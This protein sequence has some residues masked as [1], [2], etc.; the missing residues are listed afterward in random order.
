MA[1]QPP[2]LRGDTL[3]INFERRTAAATDI[4]APA[5]SVRQT[6]R[7]CSGVTTTDRGP[8]GANY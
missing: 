1:Q 4:V 7:P 6:G 5:S 8:A 3:I 2:T